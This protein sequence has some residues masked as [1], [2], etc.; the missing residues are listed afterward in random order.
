MPERL[1][2]VAQAQQRGRAARKEGAAAAAQ[3]PLLAVTVHRLS[4]HEGAYASNEAAAACRLAE[5]RPG[6]RRSCILRI[7]SNLKYDVL[8]AL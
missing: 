8:D 7:F 2:P 1:Y 5:R 3:A 4:V 6:M